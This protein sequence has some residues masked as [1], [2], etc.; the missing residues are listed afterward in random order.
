[1]PCRREGRPQASA[2]A[3]LYAPP[4]PPAPPIKPASSVSSPRCAAWAATASSSPAE[5]PWRTGNAPSRSSWHASQP[6][7]PSHRGG[8]PST[9]AGACWQGGRLWAARGPR[10]PTLARL[11]SASIASTSTMLGMPPTRPAVPVSAAAVLPFLRWCAQRLPCRRKATQVPPM[12]WSPC[13]SSSGRGPAAPERL[14][15]LLA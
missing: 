8:A 13:A 15:A 5:T 14:R 9:R 2:R 3:P 6:C 11:A 4:Q 10:C 7:A 1:M 12:T